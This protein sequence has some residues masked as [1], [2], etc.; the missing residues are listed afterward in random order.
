MRELL[1][2]M[3]GWQA[4]GIGFG[5]AVAVR[6]F[7]SAPRDV[8]AALLAAD[9]ERIA[10]S[11]SGGC[12]EGAAAEEVRRARRD[13]R[14]R[15]LRYGISDEMAWDVGLAC[16]GTIDVLV[17]PE[18]NAATLAAAEATAAGGEARVLVTRLPSDAPGPELGP[19][20][21]GTGEKPAEPIVVDAEGPTPGLLPAA[22]RTAAA[23]AR[24]DSVSRTVAAEGR[25][26]FVEAFAPAPRLVIVGAVHIAIPLVRIAREMGYRTVLVDRR[27]TFATRD[28]FGEADELLVDWPERAFERIGLH[29]RDAV[30]VL[31]HDPKLDE[32]AIVEALRAGCEYVGA[33]GSRRTQ[34]ERIERLQA[35]GLTPGQLD[36][37]H[38]P[39]GLDLG[40]R[41]PGEIA[42]AIMAEIVAERRGGT[43]RA[44]AA[45]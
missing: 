18:V 28:R 35:A 33:I 24:A 19:H 44:L 36:R 23:D 38:G 41:Q 16:G 26:W 21:A 3:R 22:V 43:A 9:H 30:A 17:E 29:P 2:T 42:L 10:G 37:L 6:T 8:G 14:A 40:G 32:P 12:V 31:S 1:D 34:T 7:N 20:A 15:V 11:V 13:G 27:A 45:G 4:E 25:Q 39:I 5:R